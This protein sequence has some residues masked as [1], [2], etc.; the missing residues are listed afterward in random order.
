MTLHYESSRER[1]LQ[2]R[3]VST[4]AGGSTRIF[5]IHLDGVCVELRYIDFIYLGVLLLITAL[6][7]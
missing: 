5:F 6:V 2:S 3:D 4:S 1:L 7:P